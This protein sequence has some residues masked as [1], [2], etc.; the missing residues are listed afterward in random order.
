M[1]G[2]TSVVRRFTIL[3]EI[4]IL[5]KKIFPVS[6]TDLAQIFPLCARATVIP[7]PIVKLIRLLP[8]QRNHSRITFESLFF[9]YTIPPFGRTAISIASTL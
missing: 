1:A 9:S 5:C 3:A 4:T 6:R 2:A 7:F 8:R